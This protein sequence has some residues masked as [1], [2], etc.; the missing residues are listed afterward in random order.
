[1]PGL[2]AMGEAYK[3]LTR[4][5][6]TQMAQNE[7][8]RDLLNRQIKSAQRQGLVSNVAGGAGLGFSVGG[9]VGALI[10]GGIGLLGSMLS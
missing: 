1:M 3:D 10:G 6:L 9:P 8:S 7:Q 4:R 5:G 2:I